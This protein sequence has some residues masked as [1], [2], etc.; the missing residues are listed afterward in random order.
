MAR[1]ALHAHALEFVHPI[2]GV[3]LRI[4]SPLPADMVE[5]LAWL[6]VNRPE[7]VG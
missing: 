5:L 6:R 1:H 3:P 4:E 2:T 7:R